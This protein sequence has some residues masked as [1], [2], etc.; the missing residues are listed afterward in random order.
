MG[1]GIRKMKRSKFH[2]NSTSKTNEYEFIY[3]NPLIQPIPL[4]NN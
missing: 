4:I 3:N 2:R 1:Y